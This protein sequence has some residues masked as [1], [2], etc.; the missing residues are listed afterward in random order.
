MAVCLLG[1]CQ[2][3]DKFGDSGRSNHSDLMF[4][5]RHMTKDLGFRSHTRIHHP[6]ILG[7]NWSS[8]SRYMM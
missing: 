1:L 4:S 3:T 6:A 2:Q 5:I 8:S 7:S